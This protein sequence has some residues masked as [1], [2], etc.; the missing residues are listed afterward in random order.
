MQFSEVY[1]GIGYSVTVLQDI[2]DH[3]F[4]WSAQ[5]HREAAAKGSAQEYANV[6][7]AMF[8]GVA[9]AKTLIDCWPDSPLA[10]T[11]H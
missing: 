2:G 6:G 5:L 11:S 3:M 10:E 1:K 4:R 8:D 9:A 7:S